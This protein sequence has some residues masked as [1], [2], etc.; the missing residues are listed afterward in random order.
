ML[1][2]VEKAVNILTDLEWVSSFTRRSAG[3]LTANVKEDRT[4]LIVKILI[5]DPV[6]LSEII[7]SHGE[8]KMVKLLS[9][10][11]ELEILLSQGIIG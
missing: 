3:T 1:K 4:S 7:V 2:N 11:I 10:V 9:E 5:I 6:P 8:V